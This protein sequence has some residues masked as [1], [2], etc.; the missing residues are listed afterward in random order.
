[1]AKKIDLIDL[2]KVYEHSR[3]VVV[4][5]K[6]FGSLEDEST[7]GLDYRILDGIEI[8]KHF[9][10]FDWLINLG[11]QKVKKALGDTFELCESQKRH[12]NVNILEAGG[13]Y[14]RHVDGNQW[15]LIMS[16]TDNY[17]GGALRC[18]WPDGSLKEEMRLPAWKF[19]LLE[20]GKVPHEVMT[21]TRGRRYT[22]ILAF[23]EYG[24]SDNHHDL[25]NE[26]Y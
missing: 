22:F 18:Y 24:I 13:R 16:L 15:T 7:A 11:L 25:E 14:E 23:D 4:N 6:S 2:N 10:E 21:V 8:S 1:M 3:H 17:S 19:I 12:V 9:P 26:L 5:G 20:G